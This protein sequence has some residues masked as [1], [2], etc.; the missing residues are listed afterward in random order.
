MDVFFCEGCGAAILETEVASAGTVYLSPD[1][2]RRKWPRGMVASTGVV[3][4][5][6]ADQRRGVGM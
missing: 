2:R 5:V 1:S 6:V 4:D 3:Y